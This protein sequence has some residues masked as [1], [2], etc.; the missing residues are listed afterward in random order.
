MLYAYI[1]HGFAEAPDGSITLKCLPEHEAATF[2]AP[3]KPT[4]EEMH[5]IAAPVVVACGGHEPGPGPHDMAP[6]IADGLPH[7]VLRRY[8]HLGHFGPLQ[9]PDTIADDAAAFFLGS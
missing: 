9:D 3:D 7:G 2:E 6:K 4:I 1:E 8:E 5:A